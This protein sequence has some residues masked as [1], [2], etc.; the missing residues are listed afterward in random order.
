MPVPDRLVLNSKPLYIYAK[1]S[2]EDP[3]Y[4]KIVDALP[5]NSKPSDYITSLDVTAALRVF[6]TL[7]GGIVKPCL[8]R[9]SSTTNYSR[10]QSSGSLLVKWGRRTSSTKLATPFAVPLWYKLRLY[11]DENYDRATTDKVSKDDKHQV[12]DLRPEGVACDP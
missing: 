10:S 7:R 6:I 3:L 2:W 11:R 12:G 4:R 5:A 8:R 9:T 1:M